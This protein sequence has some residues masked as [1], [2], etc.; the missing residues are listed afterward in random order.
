MLKTHIINGA[1]AKPGFREV[2]ILNAHNSYNNCIIEKVG[3]EWLCKCTRLLSEPIAA[4]RTFAD[5]VV[6]AYTYLNF[7]VKS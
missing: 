4:G 7:V 2:K 1:T 6:D 3:N 5:A